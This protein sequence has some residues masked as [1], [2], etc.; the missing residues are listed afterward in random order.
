MFNFYKTTQGLQ[1]IQ[2]RSVDL[3]ARQRR[4]LLLID[5]PDFDIL[6]DELKQRL[7][8]TK[9]LQQ[10]LDLGFIQSKNSPTTTENSHRIFES[11]IIL[12][13]ESS[14]IANTHSTSETIVVRPVF[15]PPITCNT[16]LTSSFNQAQALMIELLQRYCGLM[17]KPLIQKIEHAQD[18]KSLKFC[19]IQWLT[20]LQESRMPA[21]DLQQHLQQ[22]NTYLQH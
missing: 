10:L 19:Q 17:A 9:I 2:K 7:A 3:N 6:S 11:E 22:L 16:S 13:A 12:P 1:E 5:T 18:S 8:P 20:A 15:I 14:H 21:Q 4:V